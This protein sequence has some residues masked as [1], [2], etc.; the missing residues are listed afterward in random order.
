VPPP[1]VVPVE[2]VVVVVGVVVL[3][4][5]VVVG[6]VVPSAPDGAGSV[7]AGCSICD[8]EGGAVTGLGAVMRFAAL[9]ASAPVDFRNFTSPG[10]GIT[11]PVAT[12]SC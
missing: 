8:V 11:M 3:V 7:P 4:G 6:V 12:A 1:L 2:G 10:A 9:R 5:V